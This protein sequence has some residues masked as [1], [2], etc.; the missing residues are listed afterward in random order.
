[1]RIPRFL[2]A[3][4]VSIQVLILSTDAAE[5]KGGSGTLGFSLHVSADGLFSPRV[6]KAM[7]KTVA[8]GSPAEA[9]G[10]A[11]GDE[12]IQVEGL[13]VPG[14]SAS[15]LKPHMEFVAGKPKKLR[16]KH[17]TGREYEVTLTRPA[18]K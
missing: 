7:V 4:L 18:S 10:L 15:V 8:A 11:V 17:S 14:T 16:L 9:A 5:A 13:D 6:S 1:M 3:C 2:V 12:L